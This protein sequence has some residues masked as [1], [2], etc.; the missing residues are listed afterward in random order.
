ME[1]A[2]HDDPF[3]RAL[4]IDAMILGAIAK[5]LFT[6]ALQDAEAGRIEIID[7]VGQDFE[8]RE[9]IQ[10]EILRQRGHFAGA[11]FVEHNLKHGRGSYCGFLIWKGADLVGRHADNSGAETGTDRID[12]VT[13]G[14]V[15]CSDS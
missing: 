9:E 12:P 13:T 1:H 7:V 11:K 2:V 6:L 4:E 14:K 10:L 8:L 3:A 15:R 5:E